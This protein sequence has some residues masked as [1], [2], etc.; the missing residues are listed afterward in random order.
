MNYKL[1]EAASAIPIVADVDTNDLF[2]EFLNEKEETSDPEEEYEDC[3]SDEQSDEDCIDV[4]Q[5][6]MEIDE[7]NAQRHGL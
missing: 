7:E 2:N 3:E 4:S 1:S 6:R 5:Q